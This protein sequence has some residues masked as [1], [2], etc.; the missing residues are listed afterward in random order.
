MTPSVVFMPVR[1]GPRLSPEHRALLTRQELASLGAARGAERA[2]GIVALK[3]AA[4]RLGAELLPEAPEWSQLVVRRRE[5]AA[6]V[7]ELGG[8]PVTWRV[9]VAHGDG[10]AV[11]VVAGAAD[12]PVHAR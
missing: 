10:L 7:L 1:Y 2:A 11:A 4:I 5:H 8:V 9:S 6:P 12:E 3:H